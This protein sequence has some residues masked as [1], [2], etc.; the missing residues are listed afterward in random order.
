MVNRVGLCVLPNK[1]EHVSC[2]EEACSPEGKKKL[3]P[4]KA[5]ALLNDRFQV[6]PGPR[7]NW[8]FPVK[9]TAVRY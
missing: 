2:S 6:I 1:G 3:Q 7:R 5:A 8:L 4:L 9:Q